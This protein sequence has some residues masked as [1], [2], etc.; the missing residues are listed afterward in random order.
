VS[1]P[2]SWLRFGKSHSLQIIVI[3][4]LFEEANRCRRLVAQ[5]MRGLDLQGIGSTLVDL[6][7]TGEC[8]ADIAD[9]RLDD[10]RKAVSSYE[11]S[12][13]ASFR[14]GSLVDDAGHERDIWRFAPESGARIVRDL[15]RSA[16]AS[17][18]TTSL[19]GHALSDAFLADLDAALPAPAM[20]VRT[21]RLASDPQDAAMKLSGVPLW[22]RAEPGEDGELAAALSVDIAAQVK[23]CAAL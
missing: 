14:G 10:W 12:F 4:P 17:S 22:R 20:R 15:K 21:V 9:V 19:A 13:V 11:P 3:E 2:H 8:P 23:R 7:G 18:S 5:I 1:N 6:P 16:L